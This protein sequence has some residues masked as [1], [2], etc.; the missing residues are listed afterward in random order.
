MIKPTDLIAI[1]TADWHFMPHAWRHRPEI[2]H[3]AWVSLDQLSKYSWQGMDLPII[4]AGDLLDTARPTSEVLSQLREAMNVDQYVEHRGFCINGNHDKSD[5]SWMEILFPSEPRRSWTH[6]SKQKNGC[7][8]RSRRRLPSEDGKVWTL[9]TPPLPDPLSKWCVYGIDYVETRE[10]LQEKLDALEPQLGWVSHNLLVLHQG[11]EGIIPK[12]SAEL[13]DGMIPDNV[14]MVL[15]GHAHVSKVVSI[16][17]KSGNSIPLLSPGSIHMCSIDEDPKKKVYFLAQDGSIWSVPITVRRT[18][19][20]DFSGG[21]ES[22]IRE[23]SIKIA[24]AL[25]KKAKPEVE[26]IREK[27]STPLVRIIYDGA[28][29]PKARSIFEMALREA[30]V[31]AHVFYKNKAEKITDDMDVIVEEGMST[32]FVASSFDYAKTAFQ[33]M[34]KDKIVRKIVE[35]ML[36]TEPSQENYTNLKG[37]FYAHLHDQKT[38]SVKKRTQ[39]PKP[40]TQ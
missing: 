1:L 14:D 19:I 5:P 40:R 12:M 36:D 32:S 27:I 33:T 10:Q 24:A 28:T 13:S 20:G 7:M 22:E 29:V 31:E 23:K 3:D 16:E 34:E 26:Q 8:L 2:C 11:V 25:R 21:T 9:E 6:L 15:C 39:S 4:A 30:G 18:V 37:E 17:T 38:V 35:T